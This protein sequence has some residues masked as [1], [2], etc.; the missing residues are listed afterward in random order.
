MAVQGLPGCKK[1][2]IKGYLGWN[3]W[4]RYVVFLALWLS[5]VWVVQH[6]TFG[7]HRAAHL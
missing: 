3:G 6:A 4:V 7:V 5:D 2:E 1:E